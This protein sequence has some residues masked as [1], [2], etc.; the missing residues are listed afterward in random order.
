MNFLFIGLGSIGQ[1]HLRN[2]YKISKN[3]KI[4]AYRRKFSTPSLNNKNKK[5]NIDLIKK[6]K[7]NLIKSLSN[8]KKYKINAAFICT[9]SSK[10]AE[11]IIQLAKQNINFFVEKPICTSKKDLKKI[12]N[13]MK[14]KKIITMV[15]YQLKFNPIIN[16][17]KKKI[18]QN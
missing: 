1:R 9:P 7:I 4:Y 10:H 5:I 12:K 8:L 3:D 13:L 16:F 2:L 6:Y 17:L 11:E 15:G 14:N 18:N